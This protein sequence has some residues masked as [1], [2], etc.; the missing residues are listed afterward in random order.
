MVL[1]LQT[2]IITLK[3][4]ERKREMLYVFYNLAFSPLKTCKEQMLLFF[5][6]ST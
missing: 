2:T 1:S 4:K 6:S 3:F 5:F